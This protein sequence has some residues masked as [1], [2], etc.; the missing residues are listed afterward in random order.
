MGSFCV[1]RCASSPGDVEE[2]DE[3]SSGSESSEGS[4]LSDT[5]LEMCPPDLA[6][7]QNLGNDLEDY[8]WT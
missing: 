8:Y 4:G 6:A 5:T 1:K 2:M 3:M 7:L